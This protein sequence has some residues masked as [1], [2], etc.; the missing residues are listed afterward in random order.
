MGSSGN[1]ELDELKKSYSG[2]NIEMIFFKVI[3]EVRGIEEDI[4]I[5]LNENN[6]N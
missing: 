4:E 5:C 1:I 2:E 6:E 3:V